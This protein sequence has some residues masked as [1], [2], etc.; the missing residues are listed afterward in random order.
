MIV[1]KVELLLSSSIQNYW[2]PISQ[3]FGVVHQ[4]FAGYISTKSIVFRDF[5]SFYPFHLIN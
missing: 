1:D 2:T 3:G 4:P 5:Q